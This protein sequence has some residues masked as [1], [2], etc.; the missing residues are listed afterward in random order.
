MARLVIVFLDALG[1][2]AKGS[3]VRRGL[4]G[5]AV[6]LLVGVVACSPSEQEPRQEDQGARPTTDKGART[7]E[8]QGTTGSD[9]AGLL[10]KPAY[11]TVTDAEAL[12]VEVH[13]AWEVLSGEDS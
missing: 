5:V 12:R 4:I 9:L 3:R 8:R 2:K 1:G 6:F 13:S 7:T 11:R 10:N